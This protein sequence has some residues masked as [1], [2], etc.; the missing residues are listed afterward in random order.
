MEDNQSS[1]YNPK[2]VEEKWYRFWDENNLFKADNES[3]K[4]PFTIVM[5]PPNV[6]G[7][8]HMGHALVNTIQD[9]LI[10][11]KRMSG[12]EAL[13]I[14]GTD[15]A[16]I[17]TQTVVE[18]HLIATQGKKRFDFPRDKF[19]EKMW[20]WKEDKQFKIL[21]QI[22]KLGC[23]CDWERLRF[24]MDDTSSDAVNAMFKKMYDQG[25]I[26]QGDY[27]VNWDPVTQTALADDEVEHEEMDSFLWYFKYPIKD[28]DEFIV[29]ATTR[30]ETMLGDVA[31]AANGNDPRFKS[32]IGKTVILPIV[33][34]EIP[35]ISDSYVDP[36]FGSGLVKIT[37]AHDFND[38]EIG[39]RHNL[40]IINIMTPDGCIVD[41]IKEFSGLK[42]LEAREAV[43]AKMQKLNLVDKIEPHNLRVGVSYRSKAIIEPF[44]S[45]QWFIKMSPFKEKLI[46]AVKDNKVNIIPP[47]WK[48]TYFYWIENI[49]DW[50]ISRQLWWGHRI[51]IWYNKEDPSKKI[52]YIGKDLPEEVLKNPDDWYQDE[53]VLDTWFSSALWPFSTLGWPN[54]DSKDY[55]KFYPTSV[56]VTGHDILFFWVARMIMMGEYAT[57]KNP[58]EKVFLHGLIYA[59]SYWRKDAD[60]TITYCSN[61]E[62]QK[63][64]LH[65]SPIPKDVFSKWEKMSKSKGNVI[66]PIEIIEKY[67]SDALRIALCSSVTNLPQIDLDRRKFEEYKNF[68]N[69]LWNASKFI[70]MNTSDLNAQDL[71]NGLDLEILTL[72][73]RWIL[74]LLNKLN[75]NIEKHLEDYSF[76]KLASVIYKFFWDEFCAYYL[77]FVKP[78]M[79][80]KIGDEKIL[81]NKKIILLIVLA[82]S[83]RALHPITPFITE[84]IFSKLKDLFNIDDLEKLNPSSNIDFYTQDFLKTILSKACIVAPYP[85]VIN[86]KDISEEIEQEFEIVEKVIK[87]IRN[88]KQEIKLS[89]KEE[90]DIYFDVNDA[91]KKV[92]EKNI[93]LIKTLVKIK[94]VHF[95]E[96][97][98]KMSATAVIEQIK[99]FI[100]LPQDLLEKE[101]E[102]LLK[103]KEKALK[104]KELFENKLKNKSF[105]ENAPKEIVEKMQMS[106]K[107]CLEKLGEIDKKLDAYNS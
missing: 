25:V 65:E 45:K 8:L 98:P 81:K 78:Y 66:D 19:L 46:N 49:R 20:E 76:D 102:R 82:N 22:E 4:E 93:T 50:C 71:T 64:D 41:D 21:N 14:P 40:Q 62:R 54:K 5:P 70:F 77:E 10:R 84:E 36:D 16:G 57:D 67:G 39:N 88:I 80:K 3:T 6:T 95:N 72:E 79:F 55:E 105:T 91:D 9:I 97:H 43:V 28:S 90:I 42:M 107:I 34:R 100:P 99:M 52:C 37:P 53:D 106:L 69:K 58:F 56:L 23:S 1:A 94:N 29:I 85:K 12:L 83:I 7:V 38:Y 47:S 33:N 60:G 75:L 68:A 13:W 74:S 11:Y 96:E 92:I 63:F 44:L 18:K 101:K 35:I 59:K 31:I 32:L 86:E 87:A 51:P 2:D 73:D 61:D 26:Y 24:T 27:L 30:P 104:Q 89:H 15:H 48:K 17:A 103:E